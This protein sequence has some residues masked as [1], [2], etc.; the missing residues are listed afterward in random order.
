MANDS[1]M[2]APIARLISFDDIKPPGAL[3][4]ECAGGIGIDHRQRVYFAAQDCRKP[5]D[6]AVFRYDTGS[7]ERELLGTLREVAAAEGNLGPNEHWQ[8]E[9]SI[10]KIHVPFMEH[11]GKIYFATHDFADPHIPYR[12]SFNDLKNHRGAHLFSLD[13]PTD[14]FRDLSK[15]N[16]G[17][18]AVRNQSVTAMDILREENK[19]VCFTFPYGDVLVHDLESGRTTC[20]QGCPEFRLD[21]EVNVTRKIVARNGRVFFS[22]AKEGFRQRE[23]NLTTGEIRETAHANVLRHGHV[24]GIVTTR[25]NKLVY[26]VDLTGQLYVFRVEE[27]LLEELGPLLPET[28]LARGYSVT[29]VHGLILSRD[30][31]KIYTMPSLIATQSRVVRR[32]MRLLTKISPRLK[33]SLKLLRLRMRQALSARLSGAQSS[34]ARLFEYEI[35]TMKR[36]EVAR[37]P[38]IAEGAWITGSGVVDELDRIYFCHHTRLTNS[39]RLIQISGL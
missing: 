38:S 23:M 39:A 30:E 17:G 15:G 16:E 18:V 9:E 11:Q 27:E 29:A 31:K 8:R 32:G 7:D 22:Y 35:T 4:N 33:A 34:G 13:L 5:R 14:T 6:V 21:R 37:F 28:D 24:A 2:S 36:R 1:E 10:A 20:H 26:L 3:L 12:D 25:D 19:L